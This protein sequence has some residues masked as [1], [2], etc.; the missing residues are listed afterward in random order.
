MFA[1]LNLGTNPNLGAGV[2]G[3]SGSTACS[4]GSVAGSSGFSSASAVTFGMLLALNRGTKPAGLGDGVAGVNGSTVCSAGGATASCCLS[5]VLAA[6]G[7]SILPALNLGVNPG[8]DVTV[9]GASVLSGCG[10]VVLGSSFLSSTTVVLVTAPALNFGVNPTF[11]DDDVA[12]IKLSVMVCSA[13]GFG[14]AA[15]LFL[16][17]GQVGTAALT[18]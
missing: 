16:F 14:C 10:T 12:S 6:G 3:A 15:F 18:Y 13:S 5:S 2:T 8:F 11:G 17:Q 1:A 7:F 4:A 9:E